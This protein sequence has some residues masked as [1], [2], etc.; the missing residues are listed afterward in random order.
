MLPFAHHYGLWIAGT[1]L[2]LVGL[3]EVVKAQEP[4]S[5]AEKRQRLLDA[6]NEEYAGR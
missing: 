4:L 2:V 3:Y 6:V 5:E 1:L